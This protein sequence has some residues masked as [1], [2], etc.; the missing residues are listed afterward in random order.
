MVVEVDRQGDIFLQ[1]RFPE[2]SDMPFKNLVD[3]EVVIKLLL[4]AVATMCRI[5]RTEIVIRFT[6]ASGV[7]II[8]DVDA[9]P[10]IFDLI[11]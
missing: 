2:I 8:I 3:I 9:I 6:R 10:V 1:E 4:R 7:I 11:I 5:K